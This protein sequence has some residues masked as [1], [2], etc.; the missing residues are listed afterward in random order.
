M[1]TWDVTFMSNCPPVSEHLYQFPSVFKNGRSEIIFDNL[2]VRDSIPL[3][4]FKITEKKV[5][6]GEHVFR[7]F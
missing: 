4:D 6:I 3:T 1:T 7:K 2:V 5:C